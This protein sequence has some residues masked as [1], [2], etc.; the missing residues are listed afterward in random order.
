[1]GRFSSQYP[2]INVRESQKN[3]KWHEDFIKAIINDSI[4]GPYEVSYQAMQNSYDFFDGTQRSDQY[5]F[6]QESEGGDVLPATWINYNKI[7]S[8]VNLLVGE[9]NA[10][11]YAIRARAV[12]KD[13]ISSKLDLKYEK[14]G[15]MN[16][17][18][19]L[20]ELEQVSG[21]PTMPQ[22]NLPETEEELEDYMVNTYKDSSEKVMESA[23]K[24]LT[25]KYE[26]QSKRLAIFRDLVITGR[27]FCKTEIE[28]GLPKYRRVDPR[29]MVFDRSSKDDFLEDA[30]YFGE[31]RYMPLS[32]AKQLFNL[33]D[34]EIKE[35]EDSTS[36][37]VQMLTD[38]HTSASVSP[39]S[40]IG[41]TS[42]SGSNLKVLVFY[43]EWQDFKYI[44]RKKSTDRFGN[45][46]YKKVKDNAKG[47]D[48]VKT[49]VKT[50]RKGTLIGGKI[51]RDWGLKENMIRS[52]DDIY[53]TKSSYIPLCHN[54]VNNQSISVVK[55]LEG[56]QEFKNVAMYNMQLAINRAGPK[57][58]SYDISQI[59][60]G[61]N[62][63]EV[64]KY[65]KTAG[66]AVVNSKKDGIHTPG[67]AFQEFDMTISNSIN[68][69]MMISEMIDKEMDEIAGVN[70]ERQGQVSAAS[71]AVGVTQA[72]ITSSQL[73][74][75]PLFEA[76]RKFE[77]NMLR[78]LSGLVKIVYGEDK[79]K[80]SPIIGDVGVDFIN[81]DVDLHLQDY[82]VFITAIP[83]LLA[84]YAKYEQ[85]LM[86]ALQQGKIE[87]TDALDLVRESGSGGDI[88]LA[89][90]RLKRAIKKREEEAQQQQMAMQQQQ[91]QGEM[92]KQQQMIQAQQAEGQ[93]DMQR[94]QANSKQ[95][96]ENRMRETAFQER[97]RMGGNT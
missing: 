94:Q 19:D 12:N 49:K 36:S 45:T 90:S 22:E 55:L 92:A 42:G 20:R 8:K 38:V 78:N 41:F 66:I 79:E 91:Q 71:Q 37:E 73:A 16:I 56:L 59:P 93:M 2:D 54:W 88:D 77:E 89:I 97:L 58:F 60:E 23:L 82:G 80:F 74:T 9:L 1:M 26:W 76:F 3:E 28:E 86:T 6:L 69:Y 27:A 11:G 51:M 33:T 25:A 63:E 52:V 44:S 40:S 72:A 65:L 21:I 67:Q 4:D 35:I 75:E 10:K 83:P 70:P 96:H 31:V 95:G 46:H 32:D 34:K 29:Y 85:F 57:G 5:N 18:E 30:T 14:L 84:D 81:N 7:R 64:L 48:I 61:W 62:I 43:G 68:Q 17:K 13:A 39:N 24:F 50:W 53:D 15:K 47:K 87:I